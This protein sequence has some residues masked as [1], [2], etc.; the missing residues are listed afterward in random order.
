MNPE[1]KINAVEKWPKRSGKSDYLKFL[2]GERLT[3]RQAIKAM[4]YSCCCGEPSVCSVQ[5]CPLLPFNRQ[6]NKTESAGSASTEPCS[7]LIE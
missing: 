6:I 5:F 4:C 3:Q 7:D 2:H 1:Q